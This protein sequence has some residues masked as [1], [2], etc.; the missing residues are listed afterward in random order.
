M[1]RT[2]GRSRPSLVADAASSFADVHL[3]EVAAH[4]GGLAGPGTVGTDSERVVA[5][6]A[7]RGMVHVQGAHVPGDSHLHDR[8]HAQ[9]RT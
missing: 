4:A 7:G 8:S 6:F 5:R 9:V 1:A 2:P 3:I